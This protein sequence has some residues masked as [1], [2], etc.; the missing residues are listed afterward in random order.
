MYCTLVYKTSLQVDI[1]GSLEVFVFPECSVAI[2]ATHMWTPL[3]HPP[4]DMHTHTQT[5]TY[6]QALLNIDKQSRKG[7]K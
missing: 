1:Y 4:P 7:K 2:I 6:T 5:H 3:A